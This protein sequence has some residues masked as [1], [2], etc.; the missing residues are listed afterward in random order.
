M[1]KKRRLELNWTQKD[2]RAELEPRI[3]LENLA[4]SYDARHRVTEERLCF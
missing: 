3:L 1:T 2:A 4:R